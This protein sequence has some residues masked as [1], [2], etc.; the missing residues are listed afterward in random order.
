M[1]N[2]VGC[3]CAISTRVIELEKQ[4]RKVRLQLADI[5]EVLRSAKGAAK[6][7]LQVQKEQLQN[8]LQ[9][10]Q[11]HKNATKRHFQRYIEATGYVP[12]R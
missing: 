12:P 5:D 7:R 4:R 10:T 2:A 9:A 11:R 6:A 3:G 8:V 1:G